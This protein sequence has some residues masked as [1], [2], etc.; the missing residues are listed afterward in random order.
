MKGQRV[1]AR[2][3]VQARHSMESQSRGKS[4]GVRVI[5]FHVSVLARIRLLLNHR[6]GIKDELM[7][8]E[9]K[10]LRAINGD[11]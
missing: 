8:N 11:W 4:G 1:T 10:T 5:Y 7:P 9:R 6:K 3:L 2:E